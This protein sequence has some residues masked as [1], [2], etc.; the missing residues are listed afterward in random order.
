VGG[1][2][3]VRPIDLEVIPVDAI[4]LLKND[5][6]KVKALFRKL[7]SHD[8]SVV[9]RICAELTVHSAI[10]ERLFYPVARGCVEDLDVD[11]AYE[12]HRVVKRL[13]SELESMTSDDEAFEAKA[14]V[15]ME[16]VEHHVDEE[17]GE[18][19]PSVR[20]ALGRKRLQ[21]LG[22]EL[23]AM[24]SDLTATVGTKRRAHAIMSSRA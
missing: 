21:E 19:F 4:V 20:A 6:K 1:V 9:P 11:E 12:E 18:L 10:E 13:I 14:V 17:E 24:K 5:H 22:V 8:L 2:R 3:S 23:E 7:K 15:L 16:L